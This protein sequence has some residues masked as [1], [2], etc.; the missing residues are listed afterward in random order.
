MTDRFDYDEL[1]LFHENTGIIENFVFPGR[2]ER[3]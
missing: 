2:R 1:G 3:P